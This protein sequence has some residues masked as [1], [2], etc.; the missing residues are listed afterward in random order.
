MEGSKKDLFNRNGCLSSYAICA[1]AKNTLGRN[2]LALV[3]EH[4]KTCELCSEAVR[5]YKNYHHSVLFN[6]DL[7]FLSRRIRHRYNRETAPQK[8][9]MAFLAYVVISVIIILM[10]AYLLYRYFQVNL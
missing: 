5:G 3:N 6:K 4:L 8:K 9:T 7:H 10:I 1:Y 2:E